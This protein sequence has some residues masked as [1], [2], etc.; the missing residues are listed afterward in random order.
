MEYQKKDYFKVQVTNVTGT[1]KRLEYKHVRQESY[2]LTQAGCSVQQGQHIKK[3][4]VI[5]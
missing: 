1:F 2:K 5:I 4:M 3:K